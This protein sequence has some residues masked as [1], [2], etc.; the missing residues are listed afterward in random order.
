MSDDFFR[1]DLQVTAVQNGV[2][3]VKGVRLE[4]H[5][6]VTPVSSRVLEGAF[7]ALGN[8]MT[9]FMMHSHSNYSHSAACVCVR[10]IDRNMAR[11]G[12]G[13]SCWFE[14]RGKKRRKK[15]RMA[16]MLVLFTKVGHY[17][18]LDFIKW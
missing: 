13:R 1:A 12:S 10:T 15:K 2:R 5:G 11:T 7:S 9:H 3:E 8:V 4:I 14:V 16:T 17:M 6:Q 18:A